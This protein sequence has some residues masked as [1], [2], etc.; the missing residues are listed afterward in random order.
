MTTARS[1][2]SSV[3]LAADALRVLV[4]DDDRE[5][6]ARLAATLAQWNCSVQAFGA[7]AEAIARV[8][9][10]RPHVAVISLN[11]PDMQGF[12]VARRLCECAGA[13]RLLLIS[14]SEAE[15]EHERRLANALGFDFHSVKPISV[16]EFLRALVQIAQEYGLPAITP[17]HS[18]HAAE[19]R[20]QLAPQSES[21][22]A[23][24]NEPA[25]SAIETRRATSGV[26]QAQPGAQLRLL[27]VDQ[28]AEAARILADW[29]RRRGFAV[30]VC[31]GGDEAVAQVTAFAPHVIVVATEGLD[32]DACDLA[33]SLRVR[34]RAI[35]PRLVALV[36]PGRE[37]SVRCPA[38]TDFDLH[39]SGGAAVQQL[40]EALSELLAADPRLQ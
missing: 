28:G 31:L 2:E 24:P 32:V 1:A 13:R 3:A 39:L 30:K 6:V 36:E 15:Q 27:L 17:A 10:F 7:G 12:E 20:N 23:Q 38:E 34:A 29:L 35:R 5:T 11:L 19:P 22:E 26:A 14:L 18:S 37:R 4:V 16:N 8:G 25:A 21:S 33:A 40:G 9:E